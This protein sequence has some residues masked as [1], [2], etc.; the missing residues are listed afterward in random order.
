IADYGIP[1]GVIEEHRT[2]SP[3]AALPTAK[4][5]RSGEPEW[6]ESASEYDRR[7]PGLRQRLEGGASAAAALPL[8]VDG[9]VIAVA[10]FR[11]DQPRVFD[12]EEREVMVALASQAAQAFQRAQLQAREALARR[13]LESLAD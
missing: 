11:F 9:K 2:F 3:D 4:A 5:F 6:V 1:N 7:Y 10:A 13:W 12:A 8:V